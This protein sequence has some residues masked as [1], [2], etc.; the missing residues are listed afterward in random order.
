MSSLDKFLQY[1]HIYEALDKFAL[2]E[3]I[4]GETV[5]GLAHLH[6]LGIVHQDSKPANVLVSNQNYCSLEDRQELEHV[7]QARPII[8]KL[9][10]FG[11]S[12]STINQTSNVCRRVPSNIVIGTP[13]YRAPELFRPNGSK[14]SCAR[15]HPKARPHAKYIADFLCNEEKPDSRNLTLTVSQG[16][17]VEN[18]NC[19]NMPDDGTNSSTFMSVHF[20]NLLM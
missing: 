3:K 16:S 15:F 9:A 8:C 7:F 11:E 6:D 12:Q 5:A 19:S 1:V 10:D 13:A 4:A 17:S 14:L 20:G 2:W 18:A